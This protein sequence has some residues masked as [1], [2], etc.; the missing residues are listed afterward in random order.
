MSRV[1]GE[2]ERPTLNSAHM[3]PLTLSTVV[4]SCMYVCMYIVYLNSQVHT[5][6]KSNYKGANVIMELKIGVQEG[7]GR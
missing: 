4:S 7:G 1:I 6:Y 3:L 5:G 2:M